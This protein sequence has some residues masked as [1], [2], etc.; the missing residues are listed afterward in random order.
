MEIPSNMEKLLAT[1]EMQGVLWAQS[2]YQ[3]DKSDGRTHNPI[4][5]RSCTQSQQL[6]MKRKGR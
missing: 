2:T 4:E 6:C 1:P 3:T 5:N